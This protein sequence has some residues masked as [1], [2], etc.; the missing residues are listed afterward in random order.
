MK[1][2][3]ITYQFPAI[4]ETFILNQI[5]G[6][7]DRGHNVDVFGVRRPSST[8]AICHRDVTDYRLLE[9]T[10]SLTP[11]R[12][13][14]KRIQRAIKLFGPKFSRQPRFFIKILNPFIYGRRAVNLSTLY[15]MGPF[16]EHYDIIHCHFGVVGNYA[17]PIKKTGVKSKFVTTFHGFDTRL[18]CSN[19][20]SM[21]K[22]LFEFGDCFIAVTDYNY[23]NLVEFG[24]PKKKI[25]YHPLGIDVEAF[26]PPSIAPKRESNYIRIVT[27]ARLV[28]EKGLDH[29]IDAVCSL[30]DQQPDM[31]IEYHI[32]GDGPLRKQLESKISEMG[33]I[34]SILLRGEMRQDKIK[35]ELDHSHIFMLPSIMESFGLVLLEAQAKGLPVVAS[36]VGSTHE[37][38]KDGV[39]GFLVPP[40]DVGQLAKKIAV[41]SGDPERRSKM[42]KAGRQYVE[43][44]YNIN[45]LNDQLVK[46]YEK[47]LTQ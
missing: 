15:L 21:Y 35:D 41:L 47:L 45:Q 18:G 36:K 39:S 12:H 37:A 8:D 13:K 43:E 29:G 1:I 6:L 17:L 10:V 11:P 5:T 40:G 4:S 23:N 2:A 42:G 31:K 7:I 30:I 19:N 26:H 27:V 25:V 46:I 16:A 34:N 3:V 33:M 24:L 22:E 20:G 14:I 9:R 32:I 28:K 38:L 44:N